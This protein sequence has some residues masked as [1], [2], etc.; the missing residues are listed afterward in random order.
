MELPLILRSCRERS[1]LRTTQ[2]LQPKPTT[3]GNTLHQLV[4]PVRKIEDWELQRNP[5]NRNNCSTPPL[6]E[7]AGEQGNGG[8]RTR[9]ACPLRFDSLARGPNFSGVFARNPPLR[10]PVVQVWIREQKHLR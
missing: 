5:D 9:L 2:R 6:P 3:P 1:N 10:Q 4:V 8:R 7:I